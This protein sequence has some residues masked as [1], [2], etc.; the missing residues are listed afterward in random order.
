MMLEV[1]IVQYLLF[2]NMLVQFLVKTNVRNFSTES[3]VL[4]THNGDLQ[5]SN[6]VYA[7]YNC[8]LFA[9]EIVDRSVSA[10]R[11]SAKMW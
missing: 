11:I 2:C 6:I 3:S 4:W 7:K 1:L 5:V 10:E 8:T 9:V